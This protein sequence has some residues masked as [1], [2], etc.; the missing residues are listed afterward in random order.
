MQFMTSIAILRRQNTDWQKLY[1]HS[2]KVKSDDFKALT[3]SVFFGVHSSDARIATAA[4]HR[5]LFLLVAHSL[6]A[7]SLLNL[8]KA[9]GTG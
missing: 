6:V 9:R 2:S 7:L 5:Q 4:I 8:K 3:L 1:H